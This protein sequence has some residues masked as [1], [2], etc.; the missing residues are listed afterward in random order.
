MVRNYIPK[1]GDLVILSFDPSSGHEQKGRR[2][3]LIISNEVFNKALGLAI[4][5]PITNTDR[6]F[7]F[8]VKLEAKNLKGFIMTEQIKSID[9]NA[10]E[11]KFVEK[12]DGNIL[13]QV[14]GITKSIIF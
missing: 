4:A 2:P 3:A 14:L 5:C 6:N 1:K 11:V 13:N 7:P 10:R 8:H 9:F 12:V